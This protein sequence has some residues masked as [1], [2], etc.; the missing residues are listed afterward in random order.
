MSAASLATSVAESTEIPTSAWCS[1]SASL[2]PSPRNATAEPASRWARR[3]RAFCSGLTLA[4]IVA[5]VDGGGDLRVVERVEVGAG[6]RAARAEPQGAA[7]RLGDER[8][9]AGDDLDGDAELGESCDRVGGRWLRLI[10]EHEEAGEGQVVLV[11]DADRGQLGSDAAGDGHDT[12]AGG[13]LAG[14]HT[15]RVVGDVDAAVQDPFGGSLGDDEALPVAVGQHRHTAAVM[16][17]GDGGDPV[18][19]TGRDCLPRR[20]LPTGRRRADCRRRRWRRRGRLRCR[21]ARG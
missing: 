18:E 6:E 2:T 13:E 21:R 15:A 7:D 1:A 9:V 12:L 10:E 20:V 8:V 11:V 5:S 3:M 4:K 14:E 17:E 16:I 19:L